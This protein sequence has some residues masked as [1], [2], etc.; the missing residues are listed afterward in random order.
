MPSSTFYPTMGY[1]IN[2]VLSRITA[3]IL[4]L[5]DITE[6]ESE[7]LDKL[8]R[9]LYPLEGLFG[10]AEPVSSSNSSFIL[11]IPLIPFHHPYQGG[12]PL[13]LSIKYYQQYLKFPSSQPK[14]ETQ[15]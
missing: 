15:S 11:S 3:E 13:H 5:S 4:S 9:M 8:L 12:L 2:T 14:T 7:K 1:L 6:N 10:D